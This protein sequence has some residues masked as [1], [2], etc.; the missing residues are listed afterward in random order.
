MRKLKVARQLKVD[1]LLVEVY[2]LLLVGLIYILSLPHKTIYAVSLAY[3]FG[4][5]FNTVSSILVGKKKERTN[6]G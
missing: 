5:T 6:A 2:G 4:A 1:L 3:F